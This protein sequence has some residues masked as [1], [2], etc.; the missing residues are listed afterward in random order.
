M[1]L[2]DPDPQTERLFWDATSKAD[3]INAYD[4][5]LRRYPSGPHADE[6]RRLIQEIRTEPNRDARLAEDALG[7]S[8]DARREI[9]RALSI[10]DH[11]PKGIDG[12]FGGGSRSAIAEWQTVNGFPRT[13]Y[14]TREQI[15]RLSQ[16]A[17]A[18]SAALEREAEQ[19]RQDLERQE[20]SYWAQ[21]GAVGDEAGLRSYLQRYPDGI[22]G[23]LARQ[24]LAAIEAA[25]RQQAA[26]QERD[27]WDQARAGN[28]V[29]AY[30][31]YLRDYPKGRF[32]DEAKDRIRALN[33][34]AAGAQ[35]RKDAADREAALGLAAPVRLLLE[36]RLQSLGLKP[37][38]VDGIFDADTRRAVRRYQTTRSLPATGYMDQVTVVR[39]MAEMIDR[40]GR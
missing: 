36:Q 2:P 5:Y 11:D 18:R 22:F 35:D 9:Q 30:R 39:L 25:N 6:A 32:A 19:H 31:A 24:R 34:E 14:L 40:S 16:Q 21:T 28:T 20:R 12:I 26:A 23:D 3:T 17:Q 27:A 8:R 38:K 37:G 10:L 33:E 29:G 15:S 13:G 4:A 1:P 7:L